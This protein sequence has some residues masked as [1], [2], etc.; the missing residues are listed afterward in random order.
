MH[1]FVRNFQYIFCT[2]FGDKIKAYFQNKKKHKN[3]QKGH[4]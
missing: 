3:G 2:D 4:K 1:I